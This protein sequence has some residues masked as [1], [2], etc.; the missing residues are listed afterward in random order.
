MGAESDNLRDSL[1]DQLASFDDKLESTAD[2]VDMLQSIPRID[3]GQTDA[4]VHH[5]PHST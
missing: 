1:V 2:D 5:A 4:V 3:W